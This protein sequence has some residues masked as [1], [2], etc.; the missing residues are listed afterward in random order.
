VR[1]PGLEP[2]TGIT[3]VEY[4]DEDFGIDVESVRE[5]LARKESGR[6]EHLHRRWEAAHRDFDKIV[7]HIVRT[8]RPQ[9]V[10]QWG[11]LLDER[12]FSEISDINIAVEGLAGPEE[13]FAVLGEAMFMTSFPLDIVEL[14]KLDRETAEHIRAKG[15]LIYE[16]TS[17]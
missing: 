17:S 4:M 12:T 6:R 11:S 15:K 1:V 10:Y 14:D 13:Y 8:F 16:R 7:E 9:R 3:Y 2:R 5:F